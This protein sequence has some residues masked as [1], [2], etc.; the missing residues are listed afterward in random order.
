M[1]LAQSKSGN[2]KM[3][4]FS[5]VEDKVRIEEQC[6]ETQT[7]NIPYSDTRVSVHTTQ[8]PAIPA[9]YLT[10]YNRALYDNPLGPGEI[11]TAVRAHMATNG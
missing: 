8:L 11:H 2:N 1:A 9:R 3:C 5:E 4:Y 6:E 7:L 10:I